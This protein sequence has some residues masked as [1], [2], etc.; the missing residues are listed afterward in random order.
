M[1][2]CDACGKGLT[3]EVQYYT[4]NDQEKVKKVECAHNKICASCIEAGLELLDED[5]TGEEI[6]Q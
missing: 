2:V 3:E 5:E 6:P 1:E 4:T